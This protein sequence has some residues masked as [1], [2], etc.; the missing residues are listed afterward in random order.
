MSGRG[1][2]SILADAQILELDPNT[3]DI[4]VSGRIGFFFPDKAAA[5]GRIMRKD[6]QQDLVKVSRASAGGAFAWNLHVGLHRTVG[7]RDEGLPIYAIEVSGTPEQLA[8]L[9]ASENLIRR[10]VEPI[11][12]AKFVG[13]FCDAVQARHAREHGKL[14][15]Q[16]LAAKKRWSEARNS[17]AATETAL[18]EEVTHAAAT[19]AGVYG[20]QESAVEAFGFSE[21]TIQR[22]I[23]IYR[24]LIAPFPP[25]LVR[26][27]ADHPAGKEQKQLLDLASIETD[28]WRL[29]VVQAL[30]A[31]HEL[32]VPSALELFALG[33]Q[34]GT[35]QPQPQHRRYEDTIIATWGRLQHRTIQFIPR[36]AEHMSGPQ[37]VAMRAAADKRIEEL[38]SA[39]KL[40]GQDV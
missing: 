20:W 13:A 27:L 14:T 29:E 38:R 23:K 31:D 36:L 15:Q 5:F 40:G 1:A 21:R 34:R 30:V 32:S 11:E 26:A 22:S 4:D 3:I 19:M 12:K 25:E 16:Q 6:G 8:Q 28:E 18:Q 10:V 24:Q 33:P 7:A 9:E 2:P 39:G 37:A 35:G 17:K